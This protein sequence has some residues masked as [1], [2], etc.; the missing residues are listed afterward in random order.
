MRTDREIREI[1]KKLTAKRRE[2]KE[3]IKS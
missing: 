3:K 1:S 2:E